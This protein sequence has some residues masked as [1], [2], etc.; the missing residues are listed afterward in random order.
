MV[1]LGSGGG[2]PHAAS[3][4][5][6]SV[7][8]SDSRLPLPDVYDRNLVEEARHLIKEQREE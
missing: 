3:S 4:A 1:K 5:G 8:D 2:S 6:D 7:P